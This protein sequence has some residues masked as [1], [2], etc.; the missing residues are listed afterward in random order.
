[1]FDRLLSP[2]TIDN[3]DMLIN[4]MGK[5]PAIR[6]HYLSEETKPGSYVRYLVVY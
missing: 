2:A 3:H 4:E 5:L 6:M 1:M